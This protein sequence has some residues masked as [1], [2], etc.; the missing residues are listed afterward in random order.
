MP[1]FDP[2]AGQPGDGP[3]EPAARPKFSRR[4]ASFSRADMPPA[5]PEPGPMPTD[6]PA[7]ARRVEKN[8]PSGAAWQEDT[9]FGIAMLLLVLIVNVL[10]VY[11]LAHLP[12]GRHEL[13]ATEMPAKESPMPPVA[14]D[15]E[16]GVTLYSQPEAEQRTIEQLDLRNHDGGTLSVSP[17]DIPAPTARALDD[18]DE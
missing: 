6:I 10:L 5:L 12:G 4:P 14:D 11:G 13:A 15:A 7:I 16:S 2:G 9:R 18:K 3:A 8:E 1:P 17:Q